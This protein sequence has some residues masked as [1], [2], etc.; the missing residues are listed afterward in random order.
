MLRVC[1]WPAAP[2]IGTIAGTKAPSATATA[3][4]SDPARLTTLRLIL[5]IILLFLYCLFK[6]LYDQ[7][8]P[9]SISAYNTIQLY[10][11][12][13]IQLHFPGWLECG[14]SD[15]IVDHGV[16]ASRGHLR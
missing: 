15:E 3:A 6:V 5:I 7:I 11:L 1:T 10:S 2:T 14:G 4:A 16:V 13:Y 12:T 8:V 9:C